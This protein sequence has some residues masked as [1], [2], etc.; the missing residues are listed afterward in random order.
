MGLEEKS[1]LMLILKESAPPGGFFSELGALLRKSSGTLSSDEIKYLNDIYDE[2]NYKYGLDLK[3]EGNT[4]DDVVKKNISKILSKPQSDIYDMMYSV[5]IKNV[6]SSTGL[7]KIVSSVD[8]L[9][10]ELE[11]LAKKY[12]NEPLSDD[13]YFSFGTA[14]KKVYENNGDISIL[15]PFLEAK[16]MDKL[17]IL[18]SKSDGDIKKWAEELKNKINFENSQIIPDNVKTDID[19]QIPKTTDEVTTPIETKTLSSDEISKKLED[20]S[21]DDQK[22]RDTID[23]DFDFEVDLAN[24]QK[25]KELM[26]NDYDSFMNNLT[27]I[28][29]IENVWIIVQ[30]SD[31]DL[32]FQQ[33]MLEVFKNNQ[34]NFTNKFP[35]NAEDIKMGIAMLEDRIMVNSN[36]SVSGIRDTNLADFGD[37][38]NGKQIYGTQGGLTDDGVWIP[39]PIEMDGELRF[40]ETPEQLL[41]DVDFLNKLNTK[42]KSMGLQPMEDYLEMMNKNITPTPKVE[43]KTIDLKSIDDK[44]LNDL[45]ADDLY[46]KAKGISLIR[47]LINDNLSELNKLYVEAAPKQEVENYL[48]ALKLLKEK[49]GDQKIY[50]SMQTG[51][52]KLTT[53]DDF[54][55]DVEL[56]Y[57]RIYDSDGNWSPLNKLDTNLKD[58]P[59]E[60]T[61]FIKTTLSDDEYSNLIK[62]IQEFNNAPANSE[63]KTNLKKI[64]NDEF[65]NVKTKLKENGSYVKS[66]LDRVDDVTAN[67]KLNSEVGTNAENKV[68]ELFEE[69]GLEVLYTASDGSPID[70]SL[71][72]DQIINDTENIFGGG[73]KTVQ[74]KN[75]LS[76]TEGEFV[77]I[78]G[79]RQFK[80]KSGTGSYKV[81][82]WMTQKISKP[83]QIDLSAFYD[84]RSGKTIVAGKQKNLIGYNT[85]QTPVYGGKTESPGANPR[86]F[87]SD[88][89]RGAFF[90][91][92][93][94]PKITK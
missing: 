14:L 61:T 13:G 56:N 8:I 83:S 22:M 19:V 5:Y 71:N 55:K 72:V 23:G 24:Q 54:I 2:F 50:Q 35:A 90:I 89:K 62:K 42:R 93:D 58:M 66:W 59:K 79:R 67:I 26:G 38:K 75:A 29:D 16:F 46:F 63:L 82:V 12:G 52:P 78:N 84:R 6:F 34:T 1:T 43:P 86:P 49:F 47:E 53:I 94:T 45:F 92:A 25:L 74:T 30:H 37:L 91:E 60:L 51:N 33:K 44:S 73:V 80:S 36:T 64:L 4:I 77:Y 9:K 15:G 57:K 3:L 11:T 32:A 7:S 81:V 41:N 31:N 21:S 17:D 39:R 85:D 69:K 18:I 27:T 28:D 48:R 70:V 68:N 76:I 87:K 65:E 88:P 20:I 10:Q 40:F